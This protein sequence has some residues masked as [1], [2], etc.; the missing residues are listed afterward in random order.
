LIAAFLGDSPIFLPAIHREK[1]KCV[2]VFTK[3]FTQIALNELDTIA[4]F[5][6]YLVDKQDFQLQVNRIL[7]EGDERELLGYYLENGRSFDD[8]TNEPLNGIVVGGG[9]W[10]S[11]ISHPDYIAKKKADIFSYFWDYLINICHMSGKPEYEVIARELAKLN[12]F[13]R[14]NLSSSFYEYRLVADRGDE[15]YSYRRSIVLDGITYC[16]LF[17]GNSDDEKIRQSRK[18]E[19]NTYCHIA[20][21]QNK[22]ISRVIGIATDQRINKETAYDFC[23]INKPDWTHED[24]EI[25]ELN[26]RDTRILQNPIV[27][28]KKFREYPGN[29]R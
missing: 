10:D 4:D 20:R 17:F 27:H 13:Q 1:D 19:L 16:F 22:D 11:W 24:Q 3:E 28:R 9:V 26:M 21:G 7:I 29:S 15:G 14:R 2:H 18:N 5:T 23:F 6:K 12:R 25:M 8:L